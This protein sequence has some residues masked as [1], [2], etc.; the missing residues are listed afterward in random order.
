MEHVPGVGL[1]IRPGIKL[2]RGACGGQLLEHH[3]PVVR[4][5]G[6]L[7]GPEGRR[8]A[9]ALQVRGP[10][11]QRLED[12]QGLVPV[13]QAHVDV[14][15]EDEH[16]VT[17]QAG[18]VH[19]PGVA[20]GVGD[21]LD[22]GVSEGVGAGTDQ[23]HAQRVDHRQQTVVGEG[24]VFDALGDGVTGSRDQLDGVEHHL[25]VDIRVLAD[26]A[27][28][29]GGALAQVEGVPV[30]ELKLPLNTDAGAR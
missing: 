9:Q 29:L 19:E 22:Q 12:G 14:S 18:A 26:G 1:Q 20:L 25:A 4:V 13:L 3:R 6:G 27:Q 21:S 23:V 8:G 15:A 16:L 5:P 30:Q 11:Q 28:D 2:V 24:N 10:G 17:P 7:P